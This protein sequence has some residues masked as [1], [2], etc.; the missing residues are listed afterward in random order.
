MLIS[1]TILVVG[2]VLLLTLLLISFTPGNFAYL[3]AWPRLHN[4]NNDGE[5]S[6]W[7]N[8]L[9]SNYSLARIIDPWWTFDRPLR[10]AQ[11]MNPVSWLNKRYESVGNFFVPHGIVW[12]CCSKYSSLCPTSIVWNPASPHWWLVSCT[13][14]PQPPLVN[15][16]LFRST[17]YQLG[18]SNKSLVLGHCGCHPI[19]HNPHEPSLPTNHNSWNYNQDQVH[20]RQT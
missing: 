14:Q 20:P 16:Q 6:S 8:C 7:T 17:Y 12:N 5:N 11:I 18:P 2:S 1:L 4:A 9:W 15:Q 13:L 19:I 10:E 3:C